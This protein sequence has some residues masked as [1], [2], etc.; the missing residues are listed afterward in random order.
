[1]WEEEEADESADVGVWSCGADYCVVD[2]DGAGEDV[3][4]G[5]VQCY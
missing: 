4:G 3:F 5:S 2:A 1:M